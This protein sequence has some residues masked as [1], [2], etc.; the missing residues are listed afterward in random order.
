MTSYNKK[1]TTIPSLAL[2]KKAGEKLTMITVYDFPFARLVDQ[3][4][5][6]IILVGDSLGMVIQGLETTNPVTLDEI[7]YH[8][9]AVKRGAPNTLIVGDMPFMSYQA[10]PEQAV[11]AAGRV[12]KEAGADCVKIEGGE[13][14]VPYVKKMVGAGIPVMGHIGLTP[15]SASAL[16]GFKV[17]GKTKKEAEQIIADAKA[18]DAA[19]VFAIVLECIPPGVT[20]TITESISA[21][22]ISTGAG[23][24]ADGFNLN[25]Y[26][27][28]GLFDQFVP[29]FV[30]Q[31]KHLAPEIVQ[32]FTDFTTAVRDKKYPAPDHMFTGSEEI[33]ALYPH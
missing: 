27:L 26:D 8:T 23:P 32:G 5:A 4:P 15:Q 19:G 3:S 20:K 22:T 16:G 13:Y 2:K 9:K 17:Q 21:L 12:I 24:H 14:F 18:L 33:N 6:E 10:S 31:Y 28:L 1:K 29:K 7:I 25:G 30:Q 11:M